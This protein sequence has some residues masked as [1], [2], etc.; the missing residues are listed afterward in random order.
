MRPVK[1]KILYI[2]LLSISL[3]YSSF[4][5]GGQG[6][7]Y[8]QIET[9]NEL[10]EK[11]Q[12]TNSDKNKIEFNNKVVK[13]V[14]EIVNDQ[15]SFEY[16]F[17]KLVYITVLD[18][19]DNKL[20]I[21]NWNIALS[22][23]THKYYGYLQYKKSRRDDL[24]VFKLNDLSDHIHDENRNFTSHK[25]WFGALYYEIVTKK[26]NRVTY[27]TLIG[28]D[29]GDLLINRK[30]VEVLHFSRRGLPR[31]GNNMFVVNRTRKDRLIYEFSSRVA[32][33]LRYNAKQDI[34][35][36]DHLSPPDT[37]YEGL[38]QYYGPDLSY[39]A[40]RFVGGRWV[41]ESDIDPDIAINYKRDRRIN[42]L[43]NE[44]ESRI[45]R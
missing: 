4:A 39:D 36:I 6:Y 26:W 40:L 38:R 20:R 17:S 27:Y 23:G 24:I 37:R 33:L 25:E 41:L 30:V 3:L 45:N 34:I 22:D 9:I 21:F 7:F 2:V 12:K 14:E 31:F 5:K 32:M 1:T 10:F 18:A 44:R 28:W 11:I 43:R 29:G 13:L 8:Y 15:K 42:A 35:V 16:D 19:D